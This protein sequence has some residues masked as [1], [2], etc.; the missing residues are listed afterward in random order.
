[1]V[2]YWVLVRFERILYLDYLGN[3]VGVFFFKILE[4]LLMCLKSLEWKL[5][6][7][8]IVD[9]DDLYCGYGFFFWIDKD[10]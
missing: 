4:G 7:K 6:N 2:I 5:V 9:I 10:L 3:D 8:L 1:M